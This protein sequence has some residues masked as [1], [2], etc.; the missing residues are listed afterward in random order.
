[1]RWDD[2]LSVV[3]MEEIRVNL[4]SLVVEEWELMTPPWLKKWSRVRLT[5]QVTACL[6][7]SALQKLLSWRFPDIHKKIEC[8][9]GGARR[10]AT[11]QG[12]WKTWVRSLAWSCSLL[13]GA[14]MNRLEV[15]ASCTTRASIWEVRKV[16]ETNR[17]MG[18]LMAS[19]NMWTAFHDDVWG[20]AWR[21]QSVWR[22]V[23][24][25][26]SF[27]I[28]ST[29]VSCPHGYFVS[30]DN[31]QNIQE[32]RKSTETNRDEEAARRRNIENVSF[33]SAS[34]VRRAEATA[35]AVHSKKG[36]GKKN[37]E[38]CTKWTTKRTILSRRLVWNETRHRQQ[39]RNR[40]RKVQVSDRPP[41]LGKRDTD[42]NKSFKKR[43]QSPLDRQTD[44]QT[45]AHK[46]RMTHRAQLTLSTQHNNEQHIRKLHSSSS[47]LHTPHFRLLT[48]LSYSAKGKDPALSFT[49]A[50]GKLH[51]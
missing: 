17:W 42:R 32:Q 31:A 45:E 14:T 50:G 51:F 46:E 47:T 24:R 19:W 26:S 21:R 37:S 7:I 3:Q 43:K 18:S 41:R 49:G 25:Y 33:L 29:F 12:S 9:G 6:S 15:W 1:M 16:T 13:I 28:T 39:A 36:K 11:S 10:D 23:H 22:G 5:Q 8:S 44:R 34:T 30:E 20:G 27:W 35:V 4:L 2:A 38:Y 40:K 48:L